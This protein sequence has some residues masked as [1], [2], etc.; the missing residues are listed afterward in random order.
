M[1][2]FDAAHRAVYCPD[3]RRF[4]VWMRGPVLIALL[5][6]ALCPFVLAWLQS[7]NFDLPH[8]SPS[9]ASHAGAASEPHGF[10]WLDSLESLL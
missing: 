2:H 1:I 10:P 4:R 7:A 9:A 5:I 3:D 8:I 6:F